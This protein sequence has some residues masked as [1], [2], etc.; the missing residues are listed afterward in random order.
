MTALRAWWLAAIAA[1]PGA[2]ADRSRVAVKA[3]TV[4]LEPGKSIPRGVVIVEDGKITAAGTDLGVPRGARVLDYGDA[5]VCAGFVDANAQ[6]GLWSEITDSTFAFTPAL[7]AVDAFKSRHLD[8]SRAAAEG[9]TTVGLAP[10]GENVVGGI[11]AVVKTAGDARIV[12]E[13]AFLKLSLGPA[14][15]RNDRYP[16]SLGAALAELER[17]F[18]PGDGGGADA[19]AMA[20]ARKDLRPWVEIADAAAVR[21]WLQLAKS[22]EMSSVVLSYGTLTDAAA[23]LAAA[24]TPVVVWPSDFNTRLAD[25]RQPAELSKA[26]V[27]I[28]IA[29]FAPLR[30]AAS[31]R[32]A[33]ALSAANGLDRT[34]AFAAITTVPAKLLGVSDRVGT[35][36]PGRDADLVVLSGDP[37]DLASGVRAVLVAGE[38][39]ALEERRP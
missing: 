19:A 8:W 18:R 29:T 25:L 27:E 2:P 31:L 32:L 4:I 30:S 6:H 37:I 17:R 34:R 22:L 23:D 11:G 38:P 3:A 26:G 14:A 15:F 39:V 33:A 7:R 13:E 9:I 21:R 16:A 35:V 36:A 10:S 1:A 20:R 12:R 28:A 5:T 24:K